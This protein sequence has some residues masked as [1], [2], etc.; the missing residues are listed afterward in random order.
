MKDILICILIFYSYGFLGWLMEVILSIIQYKKIINRGFLIG[1]ICPIYGFGG[2]IGLLF[3]SRYSKDPL[4][5]FIMCIIAASILEYITSYIMEKIFK[6]RWWDY[7]K[8]KYNINGRICLE[9]AIPFGLIGVIMTYGLNPLFLS[10]YGNFSIMFLK[11]VVI[12][13]LATTIVD[14]IISFNVI[15]NLKNISN[16]IKCDS[17]EAITK[18]VRQILLNK[19]FL[20]RRLVESFPKMK[21]SN[22][23]SILKEKIQNDKLKYKEYKKQLRR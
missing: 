20:H 4:V 12:I 18:K 22:K 14:I 3:L 5:L 10:T 13:L 9:C 8:F 17:T 16:T 23:M 19:N 6:N 21:I 7:T 1:P 2:L 15:I 11:I